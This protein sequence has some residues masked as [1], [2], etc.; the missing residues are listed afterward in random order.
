MATR[1]IPSAHPAPRE[2]DDLM[3]GNDK[4]HS[5]MDLVA[6]AVGLV[7]EG[8]Y[9]SELLSRTSWKAAP[10]RTPNSSIA[11]NAVMAS[12]FLGTL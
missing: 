12:S 10:R 6:R 5:S 1:K 3:R 4:A 7:T 2:G 9:L 11:K 8:T